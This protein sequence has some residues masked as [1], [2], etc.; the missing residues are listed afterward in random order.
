MWLN[1]CWGYITSVNITI[2]KEVYNAETVR[3]LNGVFQYAPSCCKHILTGVLY[4]TIDRDNN[5][6]TNNH[7]CFFNNN[8]VWIYWWRTSEGEPT[9]YFEISGT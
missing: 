2:N 9:K 7:S 4:I 8:R 6:I 5:M 3:R 1:V